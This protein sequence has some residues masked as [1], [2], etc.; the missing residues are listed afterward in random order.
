MLPLTALI[1]IDKTV[2]SLY[3]ILSASDIKFNN[4]NNDLC[5][6]VRV[7]S[8]S[9]CFCSEVCRVEH[10]LR[11]DYERDKCEINYC[12]VSYGV[13]ED[14]NL[15]KGECSEIRAKHNNIIEMAHCD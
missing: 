7:R 4:A 15:C 3:L 12:D 13:S 5:R 14:A 1:H 8:A 6:E 10:C 11:C 2:V 9:L